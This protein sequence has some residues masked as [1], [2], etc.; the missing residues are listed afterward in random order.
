MCAG[1]SAQFLLGERLKGGLRL[2]A[3]SKRLLLCIV[4]KGEERSKYCLYPLRND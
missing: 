3:E 2:G 1:R 4:K